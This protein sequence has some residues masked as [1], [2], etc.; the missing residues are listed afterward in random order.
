MSKD[1]V[2]HT[3]R[4]EPIEVRPGVFVKPVE[5][6]PCLPKTASG[7]SILVFKGSPEH[8]FARLLEEAGC[9]IERDQDSIAYSPTEL[10]ERVC[11]KNI[12][13]E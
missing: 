8:D 3:P 5:V 1:M 12:A 11:R 13:E 2:E 4:Y 7:A 9:V 6:V 10:G